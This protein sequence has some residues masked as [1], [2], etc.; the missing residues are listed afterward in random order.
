MNRIFLNFC[1]YQFKGNY[2]I[3]AKYGQQ[4][5]QEGEEDE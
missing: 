5:K 3:Q 1:E 4:L 2:N